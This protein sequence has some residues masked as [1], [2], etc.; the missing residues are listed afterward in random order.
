MELVP[1]PGRALVP[2]LV[3]LPGRAVGRGLST[4]PPDGEDRGER[5]ALRVDAAGCRSAGADLTDRGERLPGRLTP[6]RAVP[7]RPGFP[8]GF[9]SFLTFRHI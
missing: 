4:A 8:M 6:C 2:E 1:L 9:P 3:P 7:G 5:G